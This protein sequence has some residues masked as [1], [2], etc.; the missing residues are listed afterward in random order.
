VNR[1]REIAAGATGAA[2]FAALYLALG[3]GLP[4]SLGLAVAAAGATWLVM[5]GPSFRGVQITGTSDMSAEDIQ[6]MLEAGE[7]R[8]AEIEQAAKAVSDP[9][10]TKAVADVLVTVRSIFDYLAKNPGR[11]KRARKFLSYYLD[12]TLFIVRSYADLQASDDPDI[13]ATRK[14]ML[15]VLGTI[16]AA[17]DKQLAV[18][19]QNDVLD[20]DAEIEVLRSSLKSEGLIPDE[21]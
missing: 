2:G 20:I 7:K 13:A 8:A 18:L 6:Q 16:K 15:D 12:T 14:K 9:D 1:Y 17:F 19:L 10:F 21:E 5:S 3:L 4:V 11:V